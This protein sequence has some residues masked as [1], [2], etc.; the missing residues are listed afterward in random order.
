MNTLQSSRDGA[1]YL[2]LSA[3]KSPADELKT[4]KDSLGIIHYISQTHI[5]CPVG[6]E[7]EGHYKRNGKEKGLWT[8]TAGEGC[9]VCACLLSVVCSGLRGE[10]VFKE[11]FSFSPAPLVRVLK[12]IQNRVHAHLLKNKMIDKFFFFFGAK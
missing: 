7:Y 9:V 4:L 5:T 12:K 6:R 10:V 2:S 1:P 8:L 3:S 11:I